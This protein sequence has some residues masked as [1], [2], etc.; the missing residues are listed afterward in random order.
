MEWSRCNFST[1]NTTNYC[2]RLDIN[3]LSR[4]LFTMLKIISKNSKIQIHKNLFVKGSK[5]FLPE[6]LEVSPC[7]MISQDN[8]LGQGWTTLSTF[9]SLE[10]LYWLKWGF[11][12]VVIGYIY[13]QKCNENAKLNWVITFWILVAFFQNINKKIIPDSKYKNILA[14]FLAF[15][16]QFWL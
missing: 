15:S 2:I 9:E 3:I 11:V 1:Q 10:S 4:W 6:I 13:S 7:M 14:F 16:L 12:I 8:L 5:C